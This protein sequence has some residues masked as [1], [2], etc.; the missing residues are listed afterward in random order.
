MVD[1]DNDFQR[2]REVIEKTK[3]DLDEA[4]KREEA[5]AKQLA[6]IEP[7]YSKYMQ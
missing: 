4:C 2:A 3:E 6:Y 7:K 5:L 1:S